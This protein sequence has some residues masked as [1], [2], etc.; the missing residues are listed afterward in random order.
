MRHVRQARQIDIQK[1]A[2][3]PQ[4]DWPILYFQNLSSKYFLKFGKIFLFFL[5]PELL[6][7]H[8]RELLEVAGEERL[9]GEAEVDGDGLDALVGGAEE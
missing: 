4:K 8:A 9:V 6:G 1:G 5:R 7:C 2:Q 3:C